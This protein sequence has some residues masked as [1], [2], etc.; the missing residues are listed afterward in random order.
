MHE[1]LTARHFQPH[2]GTDFAVAGHEPAVALKLI[3]VSK[4]GHPAPGREPFS[5]TFS[6]PLEPLL[7]QAI[8]SFEHELLGALDIFIVPVSRDAESVQY[9]AV[10]N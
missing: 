6:G 7:P 10:F 9:E 2:V 4:G 5:L 3:A 1:S 8:Y